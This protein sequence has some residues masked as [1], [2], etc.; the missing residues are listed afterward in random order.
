M[1]LMTSFLSHNCIKAGV[2]GTVVSSSSL[3]RWAGQHRVHVFASFTPLFSLEEKGSCLI[4][5]CSWGSGMLPPFLVLTR[6]VA[7]KAW[8]ELWGRD[9]CCKGKFQC[10]STY[11]PILSSSSIW[12][13]G[14]A[15]AILPFLSVLSQ[16]KTFSQATLTMS[17]QSEIFQTYSQWVYL[18]CI[19]LDG[20]VSIDHSWV[21]CL[22]PT[23]SLERQQKFWPSTGNLQIPS[24]NRNVREFLREPWR[25]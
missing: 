19:Q 1:F 15:T 18:C 2:G 8:G 6:L 23:L 7:G 12:I 24:Y 4:M 5:K 22:A 3:T 25:L 14:V 9:C 16:E 10:S 21:L 20:L 11:S 13:S 17:D